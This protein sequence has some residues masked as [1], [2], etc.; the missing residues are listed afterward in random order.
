MSNHFT[1]KKIIFV[2]KIIHKKKLRILFLGV[3]PLEIRKK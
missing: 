3:F 1:S 2:D